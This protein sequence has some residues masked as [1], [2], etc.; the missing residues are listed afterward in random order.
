MFAATQHLRDDLCAVVV[1]SATAHKVA[2]SSGYGFS[3]KAATQS[4]GRT[5]TQQQK[6]SFL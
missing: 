4:T 2:A 1:F 5:V 6:R 3:T